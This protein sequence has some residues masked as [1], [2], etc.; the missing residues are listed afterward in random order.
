MGHRC[1]I[2]IL[3]IYGSKYVTK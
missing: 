1:L 3:I 2:I